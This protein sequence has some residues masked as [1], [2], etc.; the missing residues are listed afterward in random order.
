M[1]ITPF[2][3]KDRKFYDDNGYAWDDLP[4]YVHNKKTRRLNNKFYVNGKEFRVCALCYQ[5]KYYPIEHH[6][7]L[8]MMSNDINYYYK[9][10]FAEVCYQTNERITEDINSLSYQITEQRNELLEM[11]KKR[12]INILSLKEYIK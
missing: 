5:P 3:L 12:K 9:M 7:N 2:P 4:F 8:K 1:L 11:E 10:M 6:K